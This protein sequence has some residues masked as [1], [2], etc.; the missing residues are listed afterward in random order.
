MD[1]DEQRLG[2]PAIKPSSM[3]EDL[4]FT[5]SFFILNPMNHP[6]VSPSPLFLRLT[7]FLGFSAVLLGAFGAHLLKGTLI[8]HQTVE[9]W[10]TASFYHLTHA[11]L[12]LFLIHLPGFQKNSF[13]LFF[14]GLLLFSG[15]LY[16]LALTPFKWLGPITPIGGLLLMGGWLSLLL[17]KSNTQNRS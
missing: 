8:E 13:Y 4:Q 11:I 9:V 2:Y 15:S 17:W 16:L 10:K 3:S 5:L 6:A 12:L 1:T 7:V 14:F